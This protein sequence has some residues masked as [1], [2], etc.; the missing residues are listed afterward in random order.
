M[1]VGGYIAT[2]HPKFHGENFCGWLT[3]RENSQKIPPR[4][5]S[6]SVES[7]YNG[8]LGARGFVHYSEVSLYN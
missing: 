3:N 6:T 8:Q 7:L 1:Y 5:F 4:K 2:A